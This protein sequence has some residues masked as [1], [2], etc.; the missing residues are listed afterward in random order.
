MISTESIN[1]SKDNLL[2]MMKKYESP[3]H[4]FKSLDM[5][6]KNPNSNQKAMKNTL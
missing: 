5:T 3:E 2:K 4:K 1:R 6:S